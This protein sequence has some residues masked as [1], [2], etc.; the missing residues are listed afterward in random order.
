[1]EKQSVFRKI[2][3]FFLQNWVVSSIISVIP[4]LISMV[5]DLWLPDVMTAKWKIGL[6]IVLMVS[7]CFTVIKN[8][9]TSIDD[10]KRRNADNYYQSLTQRNV[11]TTGNIIE[12]IIEVVSKGEYKNIVPKPL[13]PFNNDG[14]RVN[15]YTRIRSYC[16]D[17]KSILSKH[18]DAAENDIGISIYVKNIIDNPE[19]DWKF[20]YQTNV[21]N[22]DLN[23][24]DVVNNRES[25]FQVVKDDVGT[26]YFREKRNANKEGHYIMTS[27]ERS[28]GLKG[29]VY[30][31]NI[32]IVDSNNNILLPLV[33]CVTTYNSRICSDKDYFAVEKA[34]KLLSKVGIEVKYEIVN[35]LLYYHMGFRE[36]LI[37]R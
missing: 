18:F 25:T 21:S 3:N 8:I 7:V 1:M 11:G 14:S 27:Y 31:E 12:G 24:G 26:V 30:C 37:Q 23:A 28:N 20:L 22:Q 19:S 17:A 13:A 9:C 10:K 33:F 2:F 34:K 36:R 35:L 5:I 4:I 6:T 32:S 16:G 29:N 15:P